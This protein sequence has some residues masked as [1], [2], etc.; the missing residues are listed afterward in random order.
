MSLAFKT[1]VYWN[2]DLLSINK[3]KIR[4]KQ[5][6]VEPHFSYFRNTNIESEVVGNMFSI[7]Y[8]CDEIYAIMD[9]ICMTKITLNKIQI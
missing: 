5:L 9:N 4:R 3:T 2:L 1:L 7:Q 6:G 8:N